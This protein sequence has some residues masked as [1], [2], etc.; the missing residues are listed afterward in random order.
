MTSSVPTGAAQLGA[1]RPHAVPEMLTC[2]PQAPSLGAAPPITLLLVPL[3]FQ[4][5]PVSLLFP[6]PAPASGDG[7]A[8]C[9]M[10]GHENLWTRGSEE[11]GAPMQHWGTGATQ[12]GAAS[13]S[14]TWRA[15]HAVTCSPGG[16]QPTQHTAQGAWP[17]GP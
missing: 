10:C 3:E 17:Q 1:P 9:N 14:M 13:D 2:S 15:L 12:W 11:R 16:K 5:S 7:A 6:Q 4:G 8:W